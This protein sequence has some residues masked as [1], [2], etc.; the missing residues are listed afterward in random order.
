MEKILIIGGVA[1]GATAGAKARRV[2]S[3]AEI[4]ILESGNDISFAN[5]GLPYYIGGDIKNRSKLILESPESF[6]DKYQIKVDIHTTATEIDRKNKIVYAVDSRTGEKREYEYTKLILAQGGRPIAPPIPG[7]KENHVFQ[8]WTLDDMDKIHSYI[9]DEEPQSAVVVGGGFIGLE[10]AEALVK[11]GLKVSLVEMQ[12][13]VM[14]L[15]EA[16]IAGFIQKELI[17]YGVELYTNKSVTEISR[18]NVVLNDGN[19]IDA[20]M[21]IMSI[22]VKP[23]LKLAQETGLAIGEAGGLLVDSYLKTSD[24]NIFAAGD[25]VELEHRVSGKKVRIPL[26]GPANRQ[27][28]IAAEN[29]LGGNHKY[30]GSIGTSIVRVFEAVAGIT[31]LS[32]KA[33]RKFGINADAITVHK[34]HHTSYYPGSKDVTVTIVYDKETGVILGGQ[35]AG[36]Q[37]AD[38]RLDVLAVAT[39]TGRTIYELAD[40]D[41]AYS[42]PLGTA[43]DVINMAA[44]A[45]ENRITGYS[46]SLTVAELDEYLENKNALWIDV[47]DL[48][49]YEK[50]NVQGAK[51]IP[52][53][54]FATKLNEIPKDKLIILYDYNG[55]K[56]HQAL[57]TLIGAGYKNVINVSGGFMSIAN[58]AMAITPKNFDVNLEE[59]EKKDINEIEKEE[60][61]EEKVKETK[62][63]DLNE[64]LIVDVRTT[65]EFLSGAYP[66]A[67]NIPL[68]ELLNRVDELGPKNRKIILYCASGS[69]SS[70]A[71]SILSRLGFTNLE[72]GGG[73][74]HMM[75]NRR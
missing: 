43:N 24:E 28:R 64:P 26:A 5:C 39:A 46:P 73:I 1:A 72:N 31:G 59:I 41:F 65:G 15:M 9:E 6:Y 58:Y 2:S 4:T 19:K 13:H 67:I 7:A 37:G 10:M 74:M 50:A 49:A 25:M 17:S 16:E 40:V 30:S 8:L 60:I 12:P 23:T 44:Y 38:R 11:R 32:L 51:N 71:I 70:Y 53:E 57:R 62:K 27:G 52:L 47:R 21:V 69:R 22:G 45:A 56:G 55:K 36:Y 18:K 14:A 35:T 20:D 29:A 48:F 75:M 66:G 34:E 3:D 42:P 63:V 54:V 33:A 68:D 61:K